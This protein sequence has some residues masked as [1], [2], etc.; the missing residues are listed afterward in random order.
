MIPDWRVAV[1]GF[2]ENDS[3]GRPATGNSPRPV[4]GRGFH[5]ANAT[6]SGNS[7]HLQCLQGNTLFFFCNS[8]KVVEK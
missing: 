7:V 4:E 1:V 6:T 3:R 5:S 8:Q 2:G